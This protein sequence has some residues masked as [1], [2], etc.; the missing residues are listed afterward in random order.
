MKQQIFKAHFGDIPIRFVYLV[1]RR[2]VFVAKTDISLAI[3]ACMTEG[4]R[5]VSEKM[6]HD[7]FD[8]FTDKTEKA[9][10]ILEVDTVGPI[11]NAYSAG[12]LLHTLSEMTDVPNNDIRESAFRVHTLLCWYGEALGQVMDAFG[13]EVTDMMNMAYEHLEKHNQAFVVHV[14][15][16]DGVWIAV[17]DPLGL[18]TDADSFD[19]LTSRVLEIAPELSELNGFDVIPEYLR[20]KF[21]HNGIYHQQRLGH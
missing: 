9:R 17:C 2:E 3:N 6:T 20:L 15:K 12:N 5:R 18:V 11:I 14:G 8:V 7:S 21:E 4:M 1:E 10:A 13:L 16:E 19:E